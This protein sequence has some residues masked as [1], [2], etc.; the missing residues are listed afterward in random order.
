VTHDRQY[1]QSSAAGLDGRRS[2]TTDT[3]CQG[4][5]ELVDQHADGGVDQS[6][7][8]GAKHVRRRG[9]ESL[10]PQQERPG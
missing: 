9:Q 10:R 2:V 6:Q 5:Y 4:Q 3:T 8:G 1:V 7:C